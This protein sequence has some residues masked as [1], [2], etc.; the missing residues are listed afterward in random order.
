MPLIGFVCPACLA[1][2]DLSARHWESVCSLPGMDPGLLQASIVRGHSR[3]AGLDA[4]RKRLAADGIT[5]PVFEVT[6]IL[7]GVRQV[8]INRHI[9]YYADAQSY[10]IMEVG[11]AVGAHSEWGLVQMMEDDG[12]TPRW[13]RQTQ[14]W[15]QINGVNLVGHIDMHRRDWTILRDTKFKSQGSYSYTGLV[16]SPEDSAQ[17][18]L[19]LD[20]AHQRGLVPSDV[21]TELQVWYGCMLAARDYKTK[22]RTIPWKK[23]TA[24]GGLDARTIW[25]MRAAGSG[26]TV[27]E[28]IEI[29]TDAEA[30][31]AHGEDPIKVLEGIP[32]SCETRFN[33]TS[34]PDYCGQVWTCFHLRGVDVRRTGRPRVRQAV[35]M[36]PQIGEETV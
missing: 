12:E 32:T 25:G 19:Y 17:V 11:T 5:G 3:K 2:T 34:C 1:V 8:F 13:V 33:K 28:N 10:N 29:L 14:V 31:V 24:I 20:L 15:G 23:A 36:L 7:G 4:T 35:A 27:A 30:R 26:T 9:P 22:E 6:E 16:A 21:L 18:T